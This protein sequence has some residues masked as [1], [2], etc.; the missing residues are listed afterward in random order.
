[1]LNAAVIGCG[2]IGHAHLRALSAVSGVRVAAAVDLRLPLAEEAARE[3]GARAFGQVS[4]LPDDIHMATVATPPM[5]HYEPVR[6]LLDRGCHVLCEKPLTMDVEQAEELA[7]RASRNGKRLLLGFKMRFE[8]I[9]LRARE[10][11]RELGPLRAVVTAKM[12]PHRARPADDWVPRVGAMY[13]LSVHEFDLTRFI[14]GL[15]PTAVSAAV[16]IPEGWTREKEFSAQVRYGNHVM[17]SH[18]GVY[19]EACR[20]MYRDLTMQFIGERGY[21]VVQRPDRIALHLEEYRV[22]EV[23]PSPSSEA[24]SA[25]ITNF[26]DAVLGKSV[27]ATTPRDGVIATRLV[28]A[29]FAGARDGLKWLECG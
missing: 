9:F 27:P 18:T 23:A 3:F 16:T 7:D 20:F 12:Q 26:R 22:E 29:A 19:T 25:E 28:E 5:H 8:P 17:G 14:T 4:E 15:D 13:E 1:M 21:M 11:V 10:L 24:F 6:A 2:P